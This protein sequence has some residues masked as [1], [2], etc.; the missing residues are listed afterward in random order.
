VTA[1]GPF[2]TESTYRALLTAS[3]PLVVAVI[4]ASLL[5]LRHDDGAF[6][7]R[8]DPGPPPGNTIT[9]LRI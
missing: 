4:P 9:V 6:F 5:D 1:V 7:L 3:G 2:L 8:V